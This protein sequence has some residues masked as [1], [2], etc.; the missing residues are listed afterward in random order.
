M[1]LG[2]Q[3]RRKP[4]DRL[5]R[6]VERPRPKYAFGNYNVEDIRSEQTMCIC[7]MN[8]ANARWFRDY[9]TN[10]Y[11]PHFLIIRRE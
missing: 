2:I 6:W 4:V 3:L 11:G 7:W 5:E 1:T 10:R 8:L 9:Y